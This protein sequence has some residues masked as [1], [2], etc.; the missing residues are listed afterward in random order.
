MKKI[1]KFMV[2]YLKIII[3]FIK[4]EED[5]EDASLNYIIND[6]LQKSFQLGENNYPDSI[7][8]DRYLFSLL[9]LWF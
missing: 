9:I 5:V 6:S 2:V 8:V 7:I 3:N 1:G 4:I